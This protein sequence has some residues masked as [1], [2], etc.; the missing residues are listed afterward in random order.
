VPGNPS[1]VFTE[2][3]TVAIE[4]ADRP[5]PEA[6]QLLV[7]TS[8]SLIST[9]TELTLLSGDFAPDSAWAE[10]ASY[11]FHPGYCNIGQVVAVGPGVEEHWIG[12]R[13][14]TIAPH[15]TYAAVAVERACRV[16]RDEVPDDQAA[17]FFLACISMN[18]VRR[19]GV[20]WGDSVV[21]YGAGILGQL[22][23]RFCRLCG[24]RP[25]VVADISDARLDLLPE[26][27]AVVSVNPSRDDV[28]AAVEGAT[29]GRMADV[30]FEVT[31]NQDLIADEFKPLRRQG[32]FVVLS[33]PRGPTS[34]DFH[35]LCNAPSYSIIGV[36]VGSHPKH[37]E[38]D[39]PWTIGR[40]AELFFD[41][42][43]DGELAV[44]PLITHRAPYTD[45]PRLYAMLLEDR[46]QAMGV[47]L[48][49]PE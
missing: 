41:L 39:L 36:H 15:T 37:G 24:A 34:F 10:Y 45:A 7:H 43:A 11:P 8:R 33:S 30:V 48:E 20:G 25:V 40:N 14:G 46:S 44:A 49:W 32:R 26:D 31:G 4:D 47:I 42:V 18:G 29:R 35:D 12:T 9:G 38:L 23:A 13:V 17:F 28:V 2:P 6:G 5:S 1:I 19:S 22:A 21:V 16:Q 3:R 27:P